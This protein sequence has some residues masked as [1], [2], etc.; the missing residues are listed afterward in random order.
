MSI[1]SAVENYAA[2]RGE[3]IA[4]VVFPA[5]KRGDRCQQ[6]SRWTS[7]TAMGADALT[8]SQLQLANDEPRPFCIRPFCIIGSRV[9]AT[10]GAGRRN[11]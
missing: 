8:I 11:G 6:V 1:E 10:N 3:I 4:G 7:F 9:G 2:K 5:R